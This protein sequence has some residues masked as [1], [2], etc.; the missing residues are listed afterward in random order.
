MK[1]VLQRVSSARVVVGEREEA[2]G[3]V[4]V[5]PRGTREQNTMPFEAFLEAV[6]E[7]SRTRTLELPHLGA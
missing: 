1:A 7:L 5:R 6:T 4:A 3:T 2:D